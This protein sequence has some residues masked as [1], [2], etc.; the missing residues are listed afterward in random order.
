MSSLPKKLSRYLLE[1]AYGASAGTAARF[2]NGTASEVYDGDTYSSLPKVAIELP[3]NTG[4][5]E[6]GVLKI[7]VPVDAHA[8][9]TALASGEKHS[10]VYVTVVQVNEPLQDDGGSDEVL[11]LCRMWRVAKATKNP[12]RKRGIVK[13]EATGAK[14][15]LKVPLGMP[16][17]Y[18]CVWQLFGNGCDLDAVSDTG[19]LTAIDAA[20]NKKV[21]ITGVSVTVPGAT[22][23]KTFHRGY[24]EKDGMRLEIRDWSSGASTTFF[25]ER[26]PPAAWVGQTVTVVPGCDKSIETCRARWDNE[27]R[28]QGCG[29]A[30]PDYHPHFESP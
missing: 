22:P 5:L 7:E 26:K 10:P 30:I 23:G 11:V 19:T 25:L 18:Q 24:V 9:F 12:A 6:E 3:G 20:D 4:T 13:L 14:A 1:F 15:D 17:N 29:Y 8:L 27:E 28:F 16:A 21:T 2:T